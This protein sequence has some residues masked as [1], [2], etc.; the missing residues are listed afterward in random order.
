MVGINWNSR[1]KTGELEPFCRQLSL[2]LESGISLLESL[3]LIK[4]EHLPRTLEKWL[5]QLVG[6]IRKG[7][8]LA[9]A[10][11]QCDVKTP[12]MLLELAA[13]GEEHGQLGAALQQAADH[14]ESQRQLKNDLVTAMLYPALVLLVVLGGSGGNDGFCSACFGTDIRLLE[15]TDPLADT[16]VYCAE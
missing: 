4:K 13:V 2:L 5:E 16:R 9:T 1:L 12:P 7:Q 8:S 15:C 6:H 11:A 10:M 14:L 3:E